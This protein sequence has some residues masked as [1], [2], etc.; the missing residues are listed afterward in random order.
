MK[1]RLFE[2]KA[3]IELAVTKCLTGAKLTPSEVNEVCALGESDLMRDYGCDLYMAETV[4]LHSKKE[5]FRLRA[6]N[7]YTRMDG[8]MN[9]TGYPAKP[10]SRTDYIKESRRRLTEDHHEEDRSHSDPG[11]ML[12]YGHSKSD[13]EEGRMMKQVLR[14]IAVDA[15]RLHQMIEDG[16][17][18]PQ[19]CQ[20]KT[21][22]AQ[23]MIGSVR[24]YLEY[25][26]ERFGEDLVGEKEMFDP[27]EMEEDFGE[28]STE[29]SM[30]SWEEHDED[31][32]YDEEDIDAEDSND[33]YNWMEMQGDD[34]SDE[35]EDDYY[36][37]EEVETAQ[38]APKVQTSSA[39][40]VST[41][42]SDSD[43]DEDDGYDGAEVTVS[44]E[45][46]DD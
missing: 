4:K 41:D 7:Q 27:E 42:T 40:P 19:W 16:D 28:E 38:P 39:Q 36:E 15:Y 21:A 22:Q 24:N 12:D 9:D 37:D 17:D 35:D 2:G 33:A 11:R 13:S 32:D 46:E 3:E 23:Q 44:L 31:E 10:Y 8:L 20:Y 29:M 1:R 34:E 26:L 25:K 30:D 5:L 18:L 45:K 6:Q 43:D 14:D